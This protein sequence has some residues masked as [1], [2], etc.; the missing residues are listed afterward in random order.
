MASVPEAREHEYNFVHSVFDYRHPFIK[1]AMWRFK[2]KNARG[3]AEIFGESL[4]NK[5]L[6]EFSDELSVS[7]KEK[8]LIIPIPLHKSRLRER[9]YN[10]SELLVKAIMK[11]DK[12]NMFELA[13]EAL[14]RT[15][16][17]KPQARHENRSARQKNLTDAFFVPSPAKIRGRIVILIDDVTTTGAT[18]QSAKHALTTAHPK[19]VLAFT[20]GH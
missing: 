12:S 11:N 5:I 8:I 7:R 3:V 19:K 18:L 13:P 10:Q 20:V 9:G 14:V 17:T 15:R 4:Y 2:Y 16:A 6:D 1:R